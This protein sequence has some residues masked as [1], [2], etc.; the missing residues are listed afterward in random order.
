MCS[1]PLTVPDKF[2][3]SD[4]REIKKT[5]IDAIDLLLPDAILYRSEVCEDLHDTIRHILIERVIAAI[6]GDTVTL[7]DVSALIIRQATLEPQCLPYRIDRHNI[8]VVVRE[9][10]DG[11]V[12]ERS[13]KYLLDACVKRDAVHQRDR[14][15]LHCGALH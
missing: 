3:W 11:F 1:Y 9:D 12:V 14:V 4:M 7:D 13:V 5:L 8:S 2:L 10:N 6:H 15:T